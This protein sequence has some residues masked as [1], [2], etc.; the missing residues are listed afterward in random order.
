MEEQLDIEDNEVWITT[1]DLTGAEV[2]IMC[3]FAKDK[4]L[5]KWAIEEDDLHS[6]MA[7]RCW[8]AVAER[9]IKFNQ[10]LEIR[11]TRGGI[12]VLSPEM[13]INKDK[14]NPYLNL[15]T[16][17]KNGGTFGVV[18]GAKEN[19]VSSYFNISKVEG[20]LFIAT[21]KSLIPD[22]FKMVEQA[23]EFAL[24]NGY[25]LFNTRTNS[26]KYFVALLDKGRHQINSEQKA[27]IEGEARNARMQGTQADMIKEAIWKIDLFF[28]ER[29][30]ENKMLLTIHDELVWKHRGKKYGK[31]IARIM[32]EVGTLYLEGFT[33]MSAHADTGLT[34][35][36]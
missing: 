36:K 8:R 19:T 29:G 18:Y 3:A 26:R 1:S 35:T 11:D 27:K 25:L 15:R 14:Q 32:G 6:P 10:S 5:Y 4:Q 12:H 30:I 34:W 16:D 20:G 13:I 7:T 9:R 31:D 33:V 21:M 23:A 24:D 22:T 2:T 28:R 17:F